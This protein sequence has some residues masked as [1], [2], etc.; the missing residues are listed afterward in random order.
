MA[1]N[2]FC[3]QSIECSAAGCDELQDLFAFAFC[4]K[5]PFDGLYLPYSILGKTVGEGQ[6]WKPNAV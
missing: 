6:C 3:H 2:Q 4:F 5:C 1:I